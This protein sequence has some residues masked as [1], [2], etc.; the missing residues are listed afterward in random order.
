V[1]LRG[2]PKVGGRYVASVL[3][4]SR[5]NNGMERE[6]AGGTKKFRPF[7]AMAFA[8]R[9]HSSSAIVGH[10]ITAC[11]QGFSQSARVDCERERRVCFPVGF[12]RILR[13]QNKGSA[14][15]SDPSFKLQGNQL[16]IAGPLRDFQFHVLSLISATRLLFAKTIG[17]L[18]RLASCFSYSSD[19]AIR[20]H[21]RQ[22]RPE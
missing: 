5:R 13:P 11:D 7:F 1:C 19:A 18:P 2:E 17:A 20:A 16:E 15:A 10:I 4:F 14:P 9:N 22:A 21:L 6:L 3:Y 12:S 8:A